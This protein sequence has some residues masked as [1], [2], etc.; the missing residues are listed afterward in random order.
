MCSIDPMILWT[1]AIAIATIAYMVTTFF[2]LLSMRK[3]LRIMEVSNRPFVAPTVFKTL[4]TDDGGLD[5]TIQIENTGS[6]PATNLTIDWTIFINDIEHTKSLNKSQ[7][8]ILLP[9]RNMYLPA[10]F[11]KNIF[12]ALKTKESMM[13]III[14]ISYQGYADKNY[15]TYHKTKYD[16]SIDINA[17]VPIETRMD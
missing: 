3:Q 6:L 9:S 15:T 2:I 11:N 13:Q 12:D 14:N 10:I 4:Q 1:G 8:A 17:Y 7:P 5:I 16:P